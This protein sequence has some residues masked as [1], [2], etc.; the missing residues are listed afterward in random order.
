VAPP[1]Y[2]AVPT[3]ILQGGEDLR[4]PPE[5]SA[6]VAAEIPGAKRLVVPGVGHAVTGADP[7][8]CGERAILRFVANQSVPGSC[9]R[10]QTGVPGVVY[11]PVSFDAL[12]GFGALPRKIGRTVRALEATFDDLRIVI[13]PALL[14]SSGGGLRGGTWSA[15]GR[16]LTVKG[17]QAIPGVTL[18]GGGT[19]ALALTIRGAK[20]AHGTV[21]LRSGGRLAGT[22]GGHRISV[23]LS[24]TAR[25]AKRTA[26]VS[27]LAR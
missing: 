25:T 18:T 9:K 17:Y 12:R 8:G 23:R 1:P 19:S 15:R 6:R 7:S 24:T 14:T 20:A 2:P 3:L 10:V 16:R 13:S 26:H 21:T 27:E 22:L 11:G 5:N 4:T